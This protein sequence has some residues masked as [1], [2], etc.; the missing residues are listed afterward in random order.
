MKLISLKKLMRE[1]GEALILYCAEHG[2]PYDI[3]V[4]AVT[5]SVLQKYQWPVPEIV[6]HECE[7]KPYYALL[8]EG[9]SILC[10]A[11]ATKGGKWLASL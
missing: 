6:C 2:E 11:C 4:D 7:G 1:A 9:G 8:F 10:C 5:V 3:D